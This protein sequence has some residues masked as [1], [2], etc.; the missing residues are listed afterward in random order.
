MNNT[1]AR[2]AVF[3]AALAALAAGG[4]VIF[5]AE[6]NIR[7]RQSADA[8]FD[9]Q[10]Q[11]VQAELVRLRSAQ[12]AYV[13]EGQGPDYWLAQSAD[14]LANVDREL[15]AL[16]VD[17]S[18]EAT[19]SAIQAASGVLED[20]RKLDVKIRQY[21]KGHQVLMASDVIFTESLTKGATVAERLGAARTNEA[22]VNAA[23]IDQL[24]WRQFYA[25]G[26]AGV[27][28]LF[29]VLLLAPVPERE[30]DV[31]TAMRA[32]TV[33]PAAPVARPRTE[34]I[35]GVSPPVRAIAFNDVPDLEALRAETGRLPEPTTRVASALAVSS[36]MSDAPAASTFT[37]ETASAFAPSGATA[38]KPVDRPVVDLPTAARVCSD[39]ARVLD[40]GDLPGLLSRAA[41]VLD[42]PGLVVWVADRAGH[43]LFPLLAHGYSSAAVIR[44]GSIPTEAD[45]ATATAWRT[46]QVQAVPSDPAGQGALVAPIVTADGCVGVL[47]AELRDGREG[48]DD[49]RALAS[50]FAA[51]LATFVTVL[52]ESGGG[53]LAAEA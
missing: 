24:R 10:V 18:G 12:Q 47:A 16:A 4:L 1:V 27:V 17:A 45:N 32:L 21:V 30:V 50:I 53:A 6:Q 38:D 31:L 29:A 11:G 44:I 15:A 28:L 3:I 20:F 41:D 2:V 40:A 8:A 22:S 33:A 19:R 23:I 42:A 7:A 37:A 39:M 26:G 46:G 9:A 52:P 35:A 25:A 43:A 48:R 13:A 49:V 51:Q 34:S 5:D 14:A 36:A